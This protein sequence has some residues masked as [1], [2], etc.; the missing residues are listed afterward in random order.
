[1]VEHLSL[2]TPAQFTLLTP[3]LQTR[4]GSE[5]VTNSATLDGQRSVPTVTA[6]VLTAGVI[7][8]ERHNA[9]RTAIAGNVEAVRDTVT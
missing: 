6:N 5:A 8:E 3:G 9:M 4:D 2:F 1:M 7:Q